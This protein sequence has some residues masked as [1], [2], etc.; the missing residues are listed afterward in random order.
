MK[1]IL[2]S[3]LTLV[4]VLGLASVSMASTVYMDVMGGGDVDWGSF[5]NDLSQVSIGLDMPINEFK[6]ACNL[7]SGTIDDYLAPSRFHYDIDTASILL[8][9]GYA[10]INDRQLRLDVTAGFYDRIINWDY[11]EAD[12]E[13]YYIETESF[14]SLIIGFDAKLKLNKKAWVD[15]SYSF[16][17]APQQERTYSNYHGDYDVYDVDSI[18]LLNCKLNLL[19]TPEFGVSLGYNCETIDFDGTSKDKYSGVT[20]GAFFRF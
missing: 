4:L 17:L 18:S 19:L 11:H 6:F 15:F 16:G 9:G 1:K 7:T 20:V 2:I 5:S 3:G 10:L 8:K 12:S 14:Y 13:G